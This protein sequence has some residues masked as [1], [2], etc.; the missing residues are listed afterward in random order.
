MSGISS[1]NT[2]NPMVIIL[3]EEF[4]NVRK[5]LMKYTKLHV[6]SLIIL[7]ICNVI[8]C[9]SVLA[10][11]PLL[12]VSEIFLNMFMNNTI[13]KLHKECNL[14]QVGKIAFHQEY[15][16][17]DVNINDVY[18]STRELACMKGKLQNAVYVLEAIRKFYLIAT[19]IALAWT[20]LV[21]IISHMFFI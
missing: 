21:L 17:Y 18:K 19:I 15:N 6:E 20:I 16:I 9:V 4:E 14:K 10:N 13:R 8:F 12:I 1:L 2:N 7:N 5:L 11:I 3:E